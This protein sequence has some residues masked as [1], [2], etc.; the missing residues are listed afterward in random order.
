MSRILLDQNVPVGVHRFLKGHD[1]STAYHM[2]WSGLS[3][4]ELLTALQT[5]DFDLLISC[6]Q[7]L[8]HQQN[9]SGRRIA[10]LV[11]DTNRWAVLRTRGTA[12]ANAS[13]VMKPGSFARLSLTRGG[14]S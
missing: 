11:L 7:N 6:D 1:I 4:G 14:P 5:A 12:I 9:L 10:V 13:D 2:G 8:D 3:N